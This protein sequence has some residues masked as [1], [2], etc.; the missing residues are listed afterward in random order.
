MANQ[1]NRTGGGNTGMA[2]I[3]GILVVVVA[4]LAYFMLSGGEVAVEGPDTALEGAAEAI[5]GD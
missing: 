5:S 2:F 3:V 1:T 4:I